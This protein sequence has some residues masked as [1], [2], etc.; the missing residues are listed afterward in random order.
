LNLG[1][2]DVDVSFSPSQVPP[3]FSTSKFCG[4]GSARI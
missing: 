3:Q 2:V 1:I 4:F